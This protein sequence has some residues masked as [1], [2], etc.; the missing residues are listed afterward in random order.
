MG[1]ELVGRN[2][3]LIYKRFFFLGRLEFGAN[4]T[5]LKSFTFIMNF[6]RINNMSF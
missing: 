6:Q 3:G 4:K 5:Q 2:C 1:K